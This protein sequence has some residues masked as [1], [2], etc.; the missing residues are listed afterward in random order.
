MEYISV[1]IAIKYCL[2][3]PDSALLRNPREIIGEIID[4]VKHAWN[5]DRRR[6]HSAFYPEAELTLNITLII[7]DDFPG[8]MLMHPFQDA[9]T[10][11]QQHYGNSELAAITTRSHNLL[12]RAANHSNHCSQLKDRMTSFIVHNFL[13]NLICCIQFQTTGAYRDHHT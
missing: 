1:T 5:I 2:F 9:P 8:K 10:Y 7:K 4:K 3:S 12:N 6:M 13:I 11:P